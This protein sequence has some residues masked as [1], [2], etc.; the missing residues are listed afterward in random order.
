MGLIEDHLLKYPL[1]GIQDK[2][3]LL[4]QSIMGPGH[5]VNDKSRV[6]NNLITEYETCKDL[7]YKYD[8]I[9]DIGSSFV[10]VYIKPYYELNRSFDK[11]IEAFM[12]SSNETNDIYF[13]TDAL[14]RLKEISNDNDKCAIDKYLGSGSI[15]ISHSQLYRDNYHP[16]YLV[17]SKKYLSNI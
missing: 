4:M 13:L 17:I 16:H 5:L 14:Q 8:L 7:C 2:I 1:M 15:L 9:E 3:K 11:L 12:L 10:R 6:E